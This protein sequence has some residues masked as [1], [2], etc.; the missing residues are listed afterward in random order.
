M[1]FS[2]ITAF[3]LTASCAPTTCP[4]RTGGDKVDPKYSKPYVFT[5]KYKVYA[6][7]D[8]VVNASNVATGG[9][10]GAQGW[11]FYRINAEKETICYDITLKGFRGEYQSPALTATHIHQADKGQNGPPR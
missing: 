5:S 4:T 6:S 10:S 11:Y 9:L 3:A 2:L 1:K 7:P 8:Q